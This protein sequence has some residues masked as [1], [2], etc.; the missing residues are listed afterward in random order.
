M[1]LYKWLGESTK[2]G[3]MYK[4]LQLFTYKHIEHYFFST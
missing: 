4:R 3:Y 1:G 2:P